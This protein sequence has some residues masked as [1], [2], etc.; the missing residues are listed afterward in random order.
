MHSRLHD[1]PLKIR[2]NVP[3]N[4]YTPEK[5]VPQVSRFSVASRVMGINGEF[6]RFSRRQ[7]PFEKGEEQ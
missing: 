2:T 6:E 3:L 4:A 5:Y 7:V 1:N